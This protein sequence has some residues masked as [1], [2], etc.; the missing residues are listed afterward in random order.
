MNSGDIMAANSGNADAAEQPHHITLTLLTTGFQSQWSVGSFRWRKVYYLERGSLQYAERELKKVNY[1]GSWHWDEIHLR[2]KLTLFGMPI[3][4]R[5]V[6][7]KNYLE[8]VTRRKLLTSRWG[9]SWIHHLNSQN[10]HVPDCSYE[11]RDTK[12]GPFSG[13]Y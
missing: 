5:H 4:N 10:A 9:G 6:Y 1:L 7:A 2:G 11:I 3:G 12:V 13:N 8:D